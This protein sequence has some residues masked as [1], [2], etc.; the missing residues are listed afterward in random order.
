[1]GRIS[2]GPTRWPPRGQR[3]PGRRKFKPQ[4]SNLVS[5]MRAG[6]GT[7]GGVLCGTRWCGGVVSAARVNRL[8][9]GRKEQGAVRLQR[10][11]GQAAGQ[12]DPEA[13][14][15]PTRCQPAAVALVGTLVH[16][17]SASMRAEATRMFWE[18]AGA[19]V[20]CPEVHYA[21]PEFVIL[22]GGNW[23]H[24]IPWALAVLSVGLSNPIE[25]PRAAHI[26][27]QSPPGNVATLCTTKVRH[28]KSCRLTVPH[29]T[30]WHGHHMPHHPF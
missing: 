25:C 18:I 1:M 21:V 8:G 13:H 27:L 24:R 20:I 14:L 2:P 26:Q 29:T 10:L 7:V 3:K 19:H 17:R 23:V 30:P 28:G 4:T 22:A 12:P 16:H 15:V 11:T 6:A 9:P 5:R